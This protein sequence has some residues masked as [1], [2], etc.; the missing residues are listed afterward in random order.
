MYPYRTRT[1]PQSYLRVKVLNDQ[2]DIQ[3]TDRTF[4]PSG[5]QYSS[6]NETAHNVAGLSVND[7]SISF[8]G[9]TDHALWGF[10]AGVGMR[11]GCCSEVTTT[12]VVAFVLGVVSDV[13]ILLDVVFDIVGELVLVYRRQ[14][15]R[16]GAWLLLQH[17]V[18]VVVIFCLRSFSFGSNSSL[19]VQVV[20]TGIFWIKVTIDID[21]LDHQIV[22]GGRQIQSHRYPTAIPR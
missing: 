3:S 19:C 12:V 2:I 16:R 15:R 18:V 1:I 14:I 9:Q 8:R 5:L 11:L 4:V 13:V 17:A 21:E 7:R 22:L 20:Q 6:A 10:N